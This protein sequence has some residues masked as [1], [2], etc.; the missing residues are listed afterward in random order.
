MPMDV[1]EGAVRYPDD[2]PCPQVD[3]DLVPRERRYISD[4]SEPKKYRAFQKGF[5]ATRNNVSFIFSETQAAAF[6][7]WYKEE[8]LEGGGWFYADWPL[9]HT[10]KDVAHRFVTRPVWK[11]LARGFFNVTATIEVYERKVGKVKNIYTSKLY[12]I[13]TVDTIRQENMMIGGRIPP[14]AAFDDGV[15]LRSH[16][17]ISA[18]WLE[19]LLDANI[20]DDAQTFNH[21]MIR[22]E[23][24]EVLLNTSISNDAQTFNHQLVGGEWT[25]KLVT[26]P[27]YDGDAAAIQ[28][29]TIVSAEFVT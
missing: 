27:Y 14:L 23:W 25:A 24:T 8:L 6:Q 7:E 1:L 3:T 4:V 28:A 13:I 15:D 11:F 20:S 10:E 19:Q 22:G 17:I 16:V 12:P 9:L 29:H 5:Q 26:Y 2:L 18:N 21:Q